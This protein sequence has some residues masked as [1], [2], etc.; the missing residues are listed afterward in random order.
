MS[1][2]FTGVSGPYTTPPG[3]AVNFTGGAPMDAVTVCVLSGRFS[4]TGRAILGVARGAKELT[5]IV[6]SAKF[7]PSG[8]MLVSAI[9]L[10]VMSG[11]RQPKAGPTIHYP[12]VNA[13]CGVSERD[14]VTGV[15]Q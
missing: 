11:R 9:V 7:S 5:G 2:D 6:S 14:R 1:V 4:A 15:V 10:M 8:R 13:E 3:D 12:Y